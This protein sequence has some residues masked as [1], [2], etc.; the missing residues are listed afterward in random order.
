MVLADRFCPS[1]AHAGRL[2]WRR[3]QPGDRLE[4]RALAAQASL[5]LP[6]PLPPRATATAAF[7]F[8]STL[9]AGA[10]QGVGGCWGLLPGSLVQRPAAGG[11]WLALRAHTPYAPILQTAYFAGTHA[12]APLRGM[13]AQKAPTSLFRD[14]PRGPLG[15]WPRAIVHRCLLRLLQPTS[16]YVL[17]DTHTHLCTRVSS[18]SCGFVDILGQE[19][20][21]T[22]TCTRAHTQR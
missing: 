15:P 1:V 19:I 14:S 10:P 9:R 13:P 22:P 16:S 21:V 2:G 17:K 3:Q 5:P 12:L 20:W 8:D 18:H 11:G 6:P 7:Y 4:R